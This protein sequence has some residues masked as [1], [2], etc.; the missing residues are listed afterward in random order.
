MKFNFSKKV[1]KHI[2]LCILCL[3]ALVYYSSST[4]WTLYTP[5][6]CDQIYYNNIAW[7]G[8]KEFDICAD[9]IPE[10]KYCPTCCYKFIYYDKIAGMQLI[11]DL[12]GIFYNSTGVCKNCI[13]K[14]ELIHIFYEKYMNYAYSPSSPYYTSLSKIRCTDNYLY[15][16]GKCYDSSNNQ[17]EKTLDTCCSQY[18]FVCYDSITHQVDSIAFLGICDTNTY[19][20]KGKPDAPC[21]N[22]CKHY[23]HQV[24]YEITPDYDTISCPCNAPSLK[25][26]RTYKFS[27]CSNAIKVNL[28]I[29]CYISANTMDI[30]VMKLSNLKKG[31]DSASI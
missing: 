8:P 13:T 24:V 17:C 27:G 20:Y 4:D 28:C 26:T 10:L 15:T 14:E 25:I 5:S 31:C 18:I 12:V 30:K 19:D 11:T 6:P 23:C 2:Y 9:T 1:A 29:Y 21:L 7:N 3:M 22:G 16:A